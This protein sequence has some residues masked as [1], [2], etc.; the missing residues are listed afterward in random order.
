[1]IAPVVMLLLIGI[2]AFMS[3]KARTPEARRRWKV[4]LFGFVGLMW[5]GIITM[6]L[7]AA[8]LQLG[9]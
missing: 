2:A 8:S 3:L 9:A 6:I 4:A 1:M 7:I 5:L